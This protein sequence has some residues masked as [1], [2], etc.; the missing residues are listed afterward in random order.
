L[1]DSEVMDA[2]IDADA[3]LLR[4]VNTRSRGDREQSKQNKR[5]LGVTLTPGRCCASSAA[6]AA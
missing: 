4:D 3:T 2:N 5:V 1:E 6:Y